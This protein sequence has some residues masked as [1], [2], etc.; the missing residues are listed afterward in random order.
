MKEY[1][2]SSIGRPRTGKPEKA[3]LPLE[4]GAVCACLK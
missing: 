1:N 2:M 3:A 4:C